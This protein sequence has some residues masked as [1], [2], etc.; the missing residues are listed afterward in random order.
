MPGVLRDARLIQVALIFHQAF[1][2]LPV[3]ACRET[4]SSHLL[5]LLCNAR[6]TCRPGFQLGIAFSVIPPNTFREITQPSSFTPCH[7]MQAKAFSLPLYSLNPNSSCSP[8]V[9][10]HHPPPTDAQHLRIKCLFGL[11]GVP[12]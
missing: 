6:G 3:S 11:G 12:Y 2:H 4:G 8:K 7:E 5:A 10:F 9:Y 1:N